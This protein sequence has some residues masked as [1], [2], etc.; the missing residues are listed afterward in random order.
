MSAD[1]LSLAVD[2]GIGSMNNFFWQQTLFKLDA[3]WVLRRAS[4]RTRGH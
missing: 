3:G 4:N 2:S 1:E